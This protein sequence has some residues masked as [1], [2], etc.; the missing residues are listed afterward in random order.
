MNIK[1]RL[2]VGAQIDC[3][4]DPSREPNLLRS[5]EIVVV[6]VVVSCRECDCDAPHP[7]TAL[8]ASVGMKSVD[9]YI[10]PP[11]SF[12]VAVSRVLVPPTDRQVEP[13]TCGRLKA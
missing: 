13:L 5:I 2:A 11:S 7:P 9:I 3:P 4:G 12:R 1:T 6:V 10:W 8:M